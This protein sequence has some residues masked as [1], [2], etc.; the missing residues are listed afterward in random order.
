EAVEQGVKA[1]LVIEAAGSVPALAT[2]V[3]LTGPG[4]TTITVGLPAPDARLEIS[5]TALVGEGRSLVGSYLGSAVPAR[6]IPRFVDMWREGRLPVERLVT[7]RLP[8][9]RI[10]EAM[11]ALADGTAL[12][13]ILTMD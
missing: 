3:A 13:Q 1:R 5:P 9:G 4:G 11:D 12:R 2:A 10:N 8:L 6:D 7:D